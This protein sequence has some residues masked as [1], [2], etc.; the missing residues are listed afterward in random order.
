MKLKFL[1][2]IGGFEICSSSAFAASVIPTCQSVL[3]S[4]DGSFDQLEALNLTG[5]CDVGNVNF[6]GFNTTFTAASVLVASDGGV[7]SLF[8]TEVG[9]NYSYFG[10]SFGSGAIGYTATFTSTEGVACPVNDTCGIVGGFSQL[11]AE[12]GNG[13]SITTADSGGYTGSYTV[14]SDGSETNEVTFS[15]VV[16]PSSL[17]KLATYNGVG[18]V[19]NFE[20]DVIAGDTPNAPE[21]TTFSLLGGGLLLGLGMLRGKKALAKKNV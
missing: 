14:S 1:L 17:T 7:G 16:A 11:A 3:T 9:L 13:A 12:E 8:G 19:S 2:F 4:G 18:G 20:T 21:P 6:D 15:M 10:G 5:G